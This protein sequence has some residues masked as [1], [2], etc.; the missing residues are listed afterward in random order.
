MSVW[1]RRFGADASMA[2]C[3]VLVSSAT[4]LSISSS[5]FTAGV[6]R[7]FVFKAGMECFPV[8]LCEVKAVQ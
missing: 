5:S 1:G 6:S 4:H 3:M 8:Y 2:S 7:E